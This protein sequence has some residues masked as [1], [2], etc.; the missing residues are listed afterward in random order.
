[1]TLALVTRGYKD[2]TSLALATR[3]YIH[4][5]RV[6]A[7]GERIKPSSLLV[8]SVPVALACLQIRPATEPID[9]TCVS[10]KPRITIMAQPCNSA[11]SIGERAV[12]PPGPAQPLEQGRAKPSVKVSTP[13][14]KVRK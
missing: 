4:L 12:A 11:A 3:G 2:D 14:V 10:S 9:Q 7:F 8:A 1:M 13:T 6:E 5:A